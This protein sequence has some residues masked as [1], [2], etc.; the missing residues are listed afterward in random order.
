MQAI[1]QEFSPQGDAD[2]AK[3]SLKEA[4]KLGKNNKI[5]DKIKLSKRGVT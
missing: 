3:D 4:E 2:S 1:D 5:L